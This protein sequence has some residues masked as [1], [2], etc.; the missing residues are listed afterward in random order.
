[1]A[2]AGKTD[3]AFARLEQAVALG[4]A[5]GGLPRSLLEVDMDIASLR[6][7]PRFAKIVAAMK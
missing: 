4:K 7:D 2:L 3:A 5:G 1:L 6:Q